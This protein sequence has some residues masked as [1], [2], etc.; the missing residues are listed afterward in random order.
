MDISPLLARNGDI[1]ENVSHAGDQ[2]KNSKE[3]SQQIIIAV[4][5]TTQE[6]QVPLLINIVCNEHTTVK[7]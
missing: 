2:P 6:Y 4:D 7:F 5:G 1:I 3:S